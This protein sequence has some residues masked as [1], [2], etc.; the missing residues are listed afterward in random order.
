MRQNKAIFDSWAW[1]K[2]AKSL[3]LESTLDAQ[4]FLPLGVGHALPCVTLSRH[5][6]VLHSGHSEPGLGL[7]GWYQNKDKCNDHHGVANSISTSGQYHYFSAILCANDIQNK[8]F[9]TIL[10]FLKSTIVPPVQLFFEDIDHREIQRKPRIVE[11]RCPS[12]FL[13]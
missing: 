9:L 13:P 2:R 12:V 1:R 10:M 8:K 11:R 3:D 5:L 4:V 7:Q 6:A